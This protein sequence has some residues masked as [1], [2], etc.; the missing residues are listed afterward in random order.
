MA[1]LELRAEQVLNRVFEPEKPIEVEFCDSPRQA[2][3]QA[4]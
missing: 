1:Y 4:V 2:P 3:L